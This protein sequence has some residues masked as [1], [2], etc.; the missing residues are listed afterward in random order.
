MIESW[1]WGLSLRLP[2]EVPTIAASAAPTDGW[3]C[4][5]DD[6]VF[7]RRGAIRK[8]GDEVILLSGRTGRADGGFHLIH[9]HDFTTELASVDDWPILVCSGFYWTAVDV[10]GKEDAQIE[11]ARCD[12]YGQVQR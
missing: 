11:C 3:H 12:K 5:F 6:G 4:F 9:F 10:R 8:E 1:N 2:S 7:D